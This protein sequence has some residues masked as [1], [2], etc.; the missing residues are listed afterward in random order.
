MTPVPEDWISNFVNQEST[1]TFNFPSQGFEDLSNTTWNRTAIPEH[2]HLPDGL[3][4]DV[5]D[6]AVFSLD[7]FDLTSETALRY[8]I[9][10][11]SQ[12]IADL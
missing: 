4:A 3:A 1:D 2:G 10:L 12:N 6:P 11:L 8:E 7:M 5:S 9:Q